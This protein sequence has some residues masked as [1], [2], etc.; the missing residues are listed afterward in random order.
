MPEDIADDTN[1]VAKWRATHRWSP[2][3]LR[4]SVGTRI[5]K[6]F[7]LEAAK[8]VLGHA[9]TNVTGVYAEMDRRRAIEVAKL[10][11]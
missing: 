9:S 8:A 2:G 5:R 1:A 10:I 6:E 11:G 3:R 7:D 4:H